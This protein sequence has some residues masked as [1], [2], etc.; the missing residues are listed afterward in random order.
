MTISRHIGL[1]P[2]VEVHK[3]NEALVPLEPDA[4]V[5]TNIGDRYR[6]LSLIGKGSVS[7]VFK[8][9]D[10]SKVKTVAVKIINV[11]EQFPRDR[12]ALFEHNARLNIVHPNLVA[13]H[14]SGLTEE[15]QPWLALECLE[16][17]TLGEL[18]R[19]EGNLSLAT[20]LQIFEQL[21]EALS[22][23]HSQSELHMNLKPSSIF[24]VDAG[25]DKFQVK[26]ADVG[27]T[28]LL[29][30][31]ELELADVHARPNVSALFM[32]PEQFKGDSIDARSDV[33]SLG[34]LMFQCL[35][36]RP[37]HEGTDLLETMDMH[38]NRKVE[39]PSEPEMPEALLA[40]LSKALSKEASTRQ[41]SVDDF[42]AE[43]AAAMK[44]IFPEINPEPVYEP[45][46]SNSYRPPIGRKMPAKKGKEPWVLLLTC[47]TLLLIVA[48]IQ[49]SIAIVSQM[50]TVR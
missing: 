14:A 17:K 1:V 40:V 27:V 48:M 47:V 38:L 45:V 41:H 9:C 25:P 36:G 4:L 16:G 22:Y 49:Q 32:S 3:V 37:L 15:A 18:L 2:T 6:V 42:A 30:E 46:Q 8:A 21:F 11:G 26:L 44:G 24:L 19:E 12:L 28:K 35:F 31:R 13:V 20:T 29:L 39:F 34:C 7:Q 43:I 50:P 33:Y 5:G 10:V 23:V